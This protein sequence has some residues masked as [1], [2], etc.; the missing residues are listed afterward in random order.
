MK[1]LK[2]LVTMAWV[3][4]LLV[5]GCLLYLFNSTAVTLDF[6]W[7]QLPDVSLALV[8]TVTFIFGVVTGSVL[9]LLLAV[10]PKR[11]KTP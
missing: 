7:V 5:A 1:L 8:L 4:S 2:R 3:L 6:I 9:S 10:W 11:R